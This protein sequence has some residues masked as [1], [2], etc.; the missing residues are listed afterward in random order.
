VSS[1]VMAMCVESVK[2]ISRPMESEKFQG[3]RAPCCL[4]E[5]DTE[6][7]TESEWESAVAS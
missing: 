1:R 2:N 3:N 7:I 5:A 4:I 6:N